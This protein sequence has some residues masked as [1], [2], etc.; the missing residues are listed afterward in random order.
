M[1]TLHEDAATDE[2][3]AP[4]CAPAQDAQDEARQDI[5][6]LVEHI[7]T[8]SVVDYGGKLHDY[9][10]ENQ[11][12]EGIVVL[13]EK[14]AP[15]GLIMRN[16]F[17]QQLGSLYGRDLFIKRPV[18]LLM[19]PHPLIVDASVDIATISMIAM[20]R[21]QKELYDMV[22]VTDDDAFLGVVSIKRFMIEL[23]KDKEKEIELLTKQK[24]LLAQANEAEVR[25]RKQIEE[26]S[27]ELREKNDS[28]KNLLDNAG[29]GFLSFGPDFAISNEYSMECVQLFRGPIGGKNFL[30]L[31]KRHTPEDA[32]DMMGSVFENVFGAPQD[33]QEKVYISLLPTEFTI[34]DKIVRVDYKVIN[35]M[36]C[37]RMMLVLTDITEKKELEQKMARERSNLRMIVK[38]L[39]KQSDVNLGFE[40]LASF[41]HQEAPTLVSS[42]PAG[43]EFLQAA[44]A[45]IFRII[46][47]FKGDFAQL[48][49]H[50]T[51]S[52]LHEIEDHLDA[53]Q[54]AETPPTKKELAAV[55]ADWDANSIIA[56]DRRIL[57][58][59]LGA[60]FFETDER[61]LI[62]KEQIQSIEERVTAN[63][64]DKDKRELLPM[65]RALRKHNV[66]DMLTVYDDYLQTIAMRL[67]KG[68]EPMPVEGDDVYIE[69]EVYQKFFKSLVHVFRNMIDHGV[70]SP[71][72]RVEAGKSELGRIA[73]EIKQLGDDSFTIAISDD[74]AGIDVERVRAKAVEKGALAAGEAERM[75]DQAVYQLLFKDSL[76]TKEEVTALSGRGVGLSAVKAEVER[77]GGEIA[78]ASELGK[79]STFT[80][81]LP[82]R[83]V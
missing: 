19:N 72:D 26:K 22:I 74:G 82:I 5:R 76:S 39:E 2:H 29:Q 37:K 57:M 44:L 42:A 10:E 67:E 15:V 32:R 18:K 47:T 61:F 64:G 11:S 55:V 60:S 27:N 52:Q 4:Q 13:N 23:S 69:K 83:D 25:H 43:E 49:L 73:C 1:E 16:E 62:S 34:Y 20:N 31:I 28:I 59:A 41:I 36:D 9:F 71:E 46:H 14:D 78:I 38:A 79:G 40:E 35:Q 3:A 66:K 80:F 48:G 6:G 75:D 77:L 81:T 17:Y 65:L 21:P 12:A 45:E 7:K 50:N 51:A 33:L 24:T 56:E 54:N 70:E 58:E 68:L 53:L 8:F 63:L 30:E